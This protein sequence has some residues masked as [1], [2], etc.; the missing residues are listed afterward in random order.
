[1]HFGCE[2]QRGCDLE[3]MRLLQVVVFVNSYV[4]IFVAVVGFLPRDRPDGEVDGR[5]VVLVRRGNRRAV[6]S[7]DCVKMKTFVVRVW[8]DL[9]RVRLGADK[10]GREEEMV[11]GK[12]RGQ[13]GW[14]VQDALKRCQC[15]KRKIRTREVFYFWFVKTQMR[16]YSLSDF[17]T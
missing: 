7:Q 10:A 4:F 15:S 16:F 1:M 2:V 11:V 6:R 14:V 9:K 17:N 3:D 5:T 12:Q 13:E 8:T